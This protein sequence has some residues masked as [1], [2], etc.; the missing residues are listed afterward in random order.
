MFE[1]SSPNECSLLF[2]LTI[3]PTS[4]HRVV[5][6]CAVFT[7]SPIA[8]KLLVPVNNQPPD[9]LAYVEWFTPFQP[10]PEANSRLFKV[11]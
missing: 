4:A 7:I 3:V 2:L 10:R 11:S 1:V 8:K 9:H 6:V 5:Q